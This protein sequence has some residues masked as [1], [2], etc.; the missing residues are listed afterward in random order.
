LDW[1]PTRYLGRG[2]AKPWRLA[3]ADLVGVEIA[4]L[5]PPAL[6]ACEAVLQTNHGPIHFLVDDPDG[7]RNALSGHT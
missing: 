5:P 7:L 4:K 1:T 3:R 6:L 2:K